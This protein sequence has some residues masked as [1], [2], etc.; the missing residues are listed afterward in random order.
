MKTKHFFVLLLV[1]VLSAPTAFGSESK[2]ETE[3]AAISTKVENKLSA[4]ELSSL[5]T[6]VE[7]IRDMDK[8]DMTVSE[9][10]ELK[11]ELKETKEN[12]R[13]DGG[14]IY[15]GSGTLILI[16]LLIILL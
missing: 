15:I 2:S 8:S 5:N 4:E 6:R 9:K 12:I 3:S 1:L 7:E 14:Y 11:K 13:R 16:I 10:R